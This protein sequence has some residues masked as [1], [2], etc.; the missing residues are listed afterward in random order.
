MLDM[1]IGQ[2]GVGESLA[3]V[4]PKYS[5]VE[6]NTRI[7]LLWKIVLDLCFRGLCSLRYLIIGNYF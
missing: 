3:F 7:R 4:F 2:Q 6:G 1:W 5:V